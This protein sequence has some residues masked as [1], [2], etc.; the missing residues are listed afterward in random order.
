MPLTSRT[1]YS[2]GAAFERKVAALLAG[3][4]YW[5]VRAAGSHGKA[6]LIAL[7]PDQVVLVNCKLSGPGG[8]PPAE[9]NAL[10][11][12]AATIGALAVVAHRPARGTVSYLRLVGP[13]RARTRVAPARPW[14]PDEAGGTP[15]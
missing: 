1:N 5:V 15:E 6:D 4:G 14:S 2:R 3:D 13:K 8:V 9:W 10:W 7:K 12:L 11:E